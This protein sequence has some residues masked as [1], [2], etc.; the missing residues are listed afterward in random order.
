MDRIDIL[1]ILALI[2]VVHRGLKL[3][4]LQLVGSTLGFIGG[5]FLGSYLSVSLLGGNIQTSTRVLLILIIEITVATSL[6]YLGG[7]AGFRLGSKISKKHL[8]RANLMLGAPFEAISLLFVVWVVSSGLTTVQTYN[9]GYYIQHSGII[10]ALDKTLPP[11]PDLIARLEKLASPNGSPNV[12]IGLEPQHTPINASNTISSK[13]VVA[14]EPSIVKVQ[15]VGCGGLVEGSGI[16]VGNNYVLTNAHVVAG[17]T[18]TTIS[19]TRG[20][21]A[22]TPIWFDPNLDVSVLRTKYLNE[23]ILTLANRTAADNTA[24]VVLGYPGGG[25]LTAVNSVVIDNIDAVGQNIYNQGQVTR[26]I[27]ELQSNI[28][29][30]N[31]GGAMIDASGQVIGLVFAKSVSQPDVG[32]SLVSTTVIPSLQKAISQNH[33]VSVGQCAND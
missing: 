31:S 16:I 11:P 3:G 8:H 29:P 12:F 7:Y 10:I 18:Q 33:Q 13:V 17:T 30:G 21:F 26:S 28:E 15:S 27:Y 22:A 6:S 23:P 9:L 5:I 14:A 25:T 20:T 4:L 24:G 32:Y 1:I 2:Y 19:D